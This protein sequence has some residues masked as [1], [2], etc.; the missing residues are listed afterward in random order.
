ME[1]EPA[2]HSSVVDWYEPPLSPPLPLLVLLSVR[3][4]SAVEYVLPPTVKNVGALFSH[5]LPFWGR[6][7]GVEGKKKV[8]IR[9]PPALTLTATEY[10]PSALTATSMAPF[11]GGDSGAPSTTAAMAAASTH[12][13]VVLSIISWWWWWPL[14]GS[15]G[16]EG[17]RAVVGAGATG[18]AAWRQVG[19]GLA[20]PVA[21][22][23][24]A[25]AANTS[26]R[27]V[28]GVLGCVVWL[29]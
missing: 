4:L 13:A 20:E 16:G 7:R 21:R 17:V 28:L 11:D 14:W 3:L 24:M 10:E 29:W 1:A 15:G 18:A 23:G 8:E 9:P 2:V 22:V 19:L 12:S 5:T 6:W 25:A 26:R 27:C